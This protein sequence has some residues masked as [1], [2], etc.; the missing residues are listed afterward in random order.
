VNESQDDIEAASESSMQPPGIDAIV[1]A[2][3][4]GSNGFPPVSIPRQ[5]HVSPDIVLART[6]AQLQML[7]SL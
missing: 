3:E 4:E 6:P 7:I 5:R 2:V 1:A